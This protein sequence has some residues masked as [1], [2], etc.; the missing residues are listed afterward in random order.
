MLLLCPILFL[1]PNYFTQGL[2]STNF[3]VCPS[4]PS[5]CGHSNNMWL[6]EGHIT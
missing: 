3:S 1:R 4:H 6:N 2:I 5:C